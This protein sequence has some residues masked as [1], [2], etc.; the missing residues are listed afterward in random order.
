ML[1]ALAGI[2][3]LL[4]GIGLAGMLAGR[5]DR[6]LVVRGTLL[7]PAQPAYDF[8]LTDQHGRPVRLSDQR[9]KVVALF[10]GYTHCPDVCPAT[11]AHLLGAQRLLGAAAGETVVDFVTVDAARDTPGVLGTY[12]ALFDPR[13]EGLTGTAAQLDR[14][15]AAYHVWHQ[16]LA[17]D[18]R[19]Y[20]V[21]HGSAIS[22]ID[23]AGRL[24]VLHDWNDPAAD[25]A[26]DMKALLK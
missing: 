19:H 10:F 16:R 1:G 24:R 22:L 11:L 2:A 20:A 23:R 7:S 4:V 18:A 15:Y 25:L 12:A 17:G 21:A 5:R 14:A 6:A 9:G 8:T 26:F 13:F 3:L